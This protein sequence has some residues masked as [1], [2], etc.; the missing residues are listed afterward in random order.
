VAPFAVP[1][2]VDGLNPFTGAV[3]VAIDGSFACAIVHGSTA[4]E[5]WCWGNNTHGQ[6]GTGDLMPRPYPT[7]VMTTT[8][9][10][11]QI[12]VFGSDQQSAAACVSSGDQGQ[13]VFCWGANES[14][15]LGLGAATTSPVLTP[16][17][18]AFA[19]APFVL[20]I[21]GGTTDDG[22]AVVCVDDNER[23][24]CW[25]SGFPPSPTVYADKIWGIGNLDGAIR[26]STKDGRYHVNDTSRS[27][28]CSS[29]LQSQ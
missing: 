13:Y 8:M 12:T 19:S 10:A 23:L 26:F 11:S 2:T 15:Q 14:G 5:I 17:A 18:V 20:T 22:G 27:I 25:G 9:G 28:D 24:E 6:L 4:A 3:R 29:L 1:I 16:T 21:Q 7:K